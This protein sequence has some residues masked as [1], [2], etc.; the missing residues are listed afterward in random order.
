MK[1]T[2]DVERI[3]FSFGESWTVVEKWDDSP[4][5]RKGIH[6]LDGTKAVDIVGVRG[7]D[8]YLIEVKDFR[9]HAIETK[10][11]QPKELPLAIGCKV[12]D[13]VAGLVGANRQGRESWVETCAQLLL[14]AKRRVHVIA[15]I[16]DPDLRAPEPLGKRL[17]WQNTR[18]KELRQR[19]AWLTPRV[20]VAS[21]LEPA[22]LADVDAE[23]LPGV[24]GGPG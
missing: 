1:R 5:Y 2:I 8:L 16:E 9:G 20:H 3:R 24:G 6:G 22:V 18:A 11:R 14:N 15:W 19:L 13:T 21:R 23:N 12:R 4:P 7:G 10:K 17:M